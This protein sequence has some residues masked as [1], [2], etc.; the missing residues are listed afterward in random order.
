MTTA[1]LHIGTVGSPRHMQQ[2][3]EVLEVL[4]TDCKFAGVKQHPALHQH[5]LRVCD[6]KDA[7]KGGEGVGEGAGKE[8]AKA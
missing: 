6:C 2:T 1:E 8:G 4:D 5:L 7:A 3:F